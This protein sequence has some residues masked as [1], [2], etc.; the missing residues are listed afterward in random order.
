MAGET[1]FDPDVRAV[2][3]ALARRKNVLISGP[4]GTGK[5]RLLSEV[6]DLFG[7]NHSG[8]GAAP[9]RRIPIPPR[10]DAMPAWFPSPTRTES[11]EVFATAFDQNTKHRD[12]MRGLVP[13]IGLSGAFE[14]SSGILYRAALHALGD[15]NAALVII[16]EINRGP[17]VAAFGSSL[18][19]L[20]GDKRLD[21]DG[22]PTSSTQYFEVMADDG[23]SERFALPA[24]LYVLAAMNEADT[25]VEPLDVAFLR[26]FAPYRLEPSVDVLC[27]HLGLKAL[28]DELPLEA[29]EPEHLYGALAA[30]WARLNERTAL[31]RGAA[32]QLGHGGLMH[33]EAPQS[34]MAAATEYSLEAWATLKAHID[35]VFFGDT[36]AIADL[37]AAG[38]KG[39]PYSVVEDVLAAQTVFRVM[40]P[41]RLSG[42]QLYG[43]LRAIA[44][45]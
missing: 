7:W 12:V 37:F 3:T 30:A 23:G 26:R 40:G 31:A 16:D 19:G 25:S 11:R 29:S 28:P 2:L 8:V 36:R 38:L 34:S 17:A 27:Q 13:S 35:E 4:P 41:Q 14:V 39:S 5:S 24:D 42:E 18:V 20:E 44:G 9:E 1:E 32:Y 6:R 10:R 21:S 45:T 22:R 33:R 43:L 15:G